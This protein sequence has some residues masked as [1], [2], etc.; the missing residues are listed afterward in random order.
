MAAWKKLSM[1]LEDIL[2]VAKMRRREFGRSGKGNRIREVVESSASINVT[3]YVETETGGAQV[4][5]LSYVETRRQELVRGN[6]CF[7]V[8]PH[9][10]IKWWAGKGGTS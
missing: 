1:M 6:R 10:D 7:R 2:V 4:G 3:P 5:K 8:A 9:L